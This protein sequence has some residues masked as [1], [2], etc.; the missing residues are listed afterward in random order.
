MRIVETISY[1]VFRELS[2]SAHV[3]KSESVLIVLSINGDIR[4]YVPEIREFLIANI[5][6]SLAYSKVAKVSVSSLLMNNR[7]SFSGY[8][9]EL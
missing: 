1:K 9:A 6:R 5:I 7:F 8:F 4:V 3:G 2:T